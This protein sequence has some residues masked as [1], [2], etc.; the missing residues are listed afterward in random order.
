MSRHD[1]TDVCES[2]VTSGGDIVFCRYYKRVAQ[3]AV[4]GCRDGASG[5]SKC[6]QMCLDLLLL[7]LSG[8]LPCAFCC[9]LFERHEIVRQGQRASILASLSRQA[10]HSPSDRYMVAYSDKK[11]SQHTISCSSCTSQLRQ[12]GTATH[13]CTATPCHPLPLV[14]AN[15]SRT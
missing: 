6:L 9:Y 2:T 1:S 4:N 5:P 13:A 7:V 15:H 12:R 8:G 10:K 3:Y 11:A 14:S